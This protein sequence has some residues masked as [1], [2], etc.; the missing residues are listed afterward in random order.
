MVIVSSYETWASRL[1]R[2]IMKDNKSIE[3]EESENDEPG[4]KP[5]SRKVFVSKFEGAF[6]NVICDKAH[7]LQNPHS[8]NTVAVRLLRSGFLWLV[9][10]TPYLNSYRDTVGLLHLLWRDAWEDDLTKEDKEK[11]KDLVDL[12]IFSASEQW[13]ATDPKRRMLLN[14]SLTGQL[15][16]PGAVDVKRH[17]KKIEDLV[18]LRRSHASTIPHSGVPDKEIK[19]R[20]LLKRHWVSTA[21]LKFKASEALEH[22]FWHLKAALNYEH[23]KKIPDILPTI[24][25]Q[26][27]AKGDAKTRNPPPVGPLR[28]LS[29][30]TTSLLLCRLHN[31]IQVFKSVRSS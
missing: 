2:S 27:T 26:P 12:D 17:S 29:L 9:T 20:S 3:E 8:Q 13:S 7:R 15:Y 4:D 31:I 14:P 21:M 6:E 23:E 30:T 24:P 5:K 11:L 18:C 28:E 16:E 1:V 22:Q 10:A 25:T 19:L